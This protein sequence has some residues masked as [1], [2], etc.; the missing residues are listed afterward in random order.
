VHVH[1]D[2]DADDD[3][4][5][6]D[7]DPPGEVVHDCSSQSCEPVEETYGVEGCISTQAQISC[8]EVAFVCPEL[9]ALCSCVKSS[10]LDGHVDVPVHRVSHVVMLDGDVSPCTPSGL[11]ISSSANSQL[12]SRIPHVWPCNGPLL[13]SH[14]PSAPCDMLVQAAI[15]AGS[16][17]V[18]EHSSDLAL[19]LRAVVLS[20]PP[21]GAAGEHICK[22]SLPG[23]GGYASP[24]N[25]HMFSSLQVSS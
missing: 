13:D 3:G 16:R 19:V 17:V 7:G 22:R 25:V 18:L 1:G 2:D 5:D 21:P 10:G 12:P 14:M 9:V 23:P 20:I 6:D 24:H 11:L 4:N 15:S 8:E